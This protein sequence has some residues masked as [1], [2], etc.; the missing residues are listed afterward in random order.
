MQL[1]FFVFEPENTYFFEATNYFNSQFLLKTTCLKP[2]SGYIIS[3][4][5][6]KREIEVTL[7]RAERYSVSG[8]EFTWRDP[9]LK[10]VWGTGPWSGTGQTYKVKGFYVGSCFGHVKSSREGWH[11]RKPLPPSAFAR[12][13]IDKIEEGPEE[14]KAASPRS[15]VL[16]TVSPNHFSLSPSEPFAKSLEERVTRAASPCIPGLDGLEADRAPTTNSE[17][18]EEYSSPEEEPPSPPTVFKAEDLEGAVFDL[19]FD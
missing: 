11:S 7:S 13:S 18:I 9:D 16:G 15:V 19:D 14:V 2:L 6:K 10:S 3:S 5:F 12:S 8:Q 1:L 17:G 4:Q